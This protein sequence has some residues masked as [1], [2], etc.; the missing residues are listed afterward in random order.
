[1]CID[2]FSDQNHTKIS[3][4]QINWQILNNNLKRKSF[5]DMLTKLSKIIYSVLQNYDI[6]TFSRRKINENNFTILSY[7]NYL[8]IFLKL[9]ETF[10]N[11]EFRTN[12][13]E[14]FHRKLNSSFNSSYP[15]HI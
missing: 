3:K 4:Q 10:D 6:Q 2:S 14:S 13:C 15:K 11:M 12:I 8:L 9:H 7:K 1:M 5:N